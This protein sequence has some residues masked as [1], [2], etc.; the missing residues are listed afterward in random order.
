MGAFLSHLRRRGTSIDVN[1]VLVL[2]VFAN[3]LL[4]SG[5]L[6]VVIVGPSDVEIRLSVVIAV[7][8]IRGGAGR[9]STARAMPDIFVLVMSDGRA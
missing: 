9:E 2:I 8:T 6:G 3:N 7:V 5:R 4:E 1:P